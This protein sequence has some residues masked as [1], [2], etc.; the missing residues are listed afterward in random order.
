[1]KTLVAFLAFLLSVF[2]WLWIAGS[3]IAALGLAF[4]PE[5]EFSAGTFVFA[6]CFMVLPAALILKGLSRFRYDREESANRQPPEPGQ[7][8]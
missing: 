3:I 2:C 6:A 8:R 7:R 5:Q 4:D 1:M